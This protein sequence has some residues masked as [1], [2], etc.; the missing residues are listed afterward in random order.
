MLIS[1]GDA[2]TMFHE[3]GHALHGLNSNVTYPTLA[4]TAVARDFVEFPSQLNE[5]WLPTRE[6]LDRFALHHET[7]KPMP[8][9][10]IA[11]IEKA[12]TFNQGFGTVEYLSSA[13]YDMKIHLAATGQAIDPSAFEKTTMA[14]LGMPSEIVMRHRPTQFGHI[15]S[16]E[17]YAAGYYDYIWAD[18]LTADAYEAFTEAGGPYDKAVAKR[19]YDSIMS[20]GNTITAS[21]AFHRFRGRDVNAKALMR[22]RGFPVT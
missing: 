19:L 13:L 3:F 2:V 5:R 20:V 8:A 21:E 6:V 18:T 15:F 4:G 7:G 10:L 12:R 9:A 22:D 16:G 17:G 11:K 1:W 14:E